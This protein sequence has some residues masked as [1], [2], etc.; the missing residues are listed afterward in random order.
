[1]A[2][3][4]NA[5]TS[6]HQKETQRLMSFSHTTN[7]HIMDNNKSIHTGFRP[8]FIATLLTGFI[9]LNPR[10]NKYRG[11]A[12]LS[13]I[14]YTC[15]LAFTWMNVVRYFFAYDTNEQFSP[16]LMIKVS[17]HMVYF[18]VALSYTLGVPMSLKYSQIMQHWNEYYATYSNSNKAAHIGKTRKR[19]IACVVFTLLCGSVIFI[20]PFLDESGVDETK[21]FML[22]FLKPFAQG[23]S[24]F[25]QVGSTQIK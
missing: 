10:K 6:K 21:N 20:A 4:S 12:V 9:F 17:L 24:S 5:G 7:V 1:M 25:S 16:M 23:Y 22:V 11:R 18:F 3:N 2:E 8:I 19:S 14:Y 13:V 15:F